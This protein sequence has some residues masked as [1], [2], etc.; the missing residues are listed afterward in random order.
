MITPTAQLQL[1]SLLQGVIS[2]FFSFG[3]INLKF[4][5]NIFLVKEWQIWKAQGYGQKACHSHECLLYQKLLVGL[6]VVIPE[7]LSLN[8][9]VF[10]ICCH[11]DR[12]YSLLSQLQSIHLH[13]LTPVIS[14]WKW[15]YLIGRHTTLKFI[16]SHVS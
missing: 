3:R 14:A 9:W 4:H 13:V 8:P 10:G 1:K 2:I 7:T 16:Y 11:S 15:S 6:G 5:K 12:V